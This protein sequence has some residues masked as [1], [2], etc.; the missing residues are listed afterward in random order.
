M[1]QTSQTK[2]LKKQQKNQAERKLVQQYR[3]LLDVPFNQFAS[4]DEDVIEKPLLN[5]R[6][7][8]K[9]TVE[10][11]Q[12]EDSQACYEDKKPHTDNDELTPASVEAVLKQ[13]RQEAL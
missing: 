3:S 1:S 8:D 6:G 4:L 13:S 11:V 7:H 12:W 10:A 2:R 9:G 5:R